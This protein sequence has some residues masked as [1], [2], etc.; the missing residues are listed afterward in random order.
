MALEIPKCPVCAND[1]EHYVVRQVG[2]TCEN[3]LRPIIPQHPGAG[4]T[5]PAFEIERLQVSTVICRK[6]GVWF[7]DMKTVVR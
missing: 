6:C 2:L 4:I 1:K 3:T 5:H 7:T